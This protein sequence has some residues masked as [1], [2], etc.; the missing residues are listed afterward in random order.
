MSPRSTTFP[1]GPEKS[2]ALGIWGIGR[3]RKAPQEQLEPVPAT[4]AVE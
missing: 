1:E 2:K 4:G 3:P